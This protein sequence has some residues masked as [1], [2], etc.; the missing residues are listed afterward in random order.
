MSAALAGY[1]VPMAGFI[2]SLESATRR[3]VLDRTGITSE[4]NYVLEFAPPQGTIDR[5]LPAISSPSLFTAVEEQLG[6][7]LESARIP[8]ELLVI[9]SVEKPS[10]N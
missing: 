10:D 8:V 3:P 9:D 1:K 6:L 5:N 2:I 4:F 7:Q